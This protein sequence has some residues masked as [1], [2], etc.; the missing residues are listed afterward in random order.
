[1]GAPGRSAAVD[2]PGIPDPSRTDAADVARALD[3]DRG[4]G[5]S[6]AEAARRLFVHYNTMKHRL[7]RIGEL[8]GADLHDPRTRTALALALEA[9]RLVQ[10]P[11]RPPRGGVSGSP[12]PGAGP[13]TGT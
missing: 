11:A 8:L 6:G 5:L 12:R 3:V 2:P 13:T 4:R 7:Q 1:M 9:H 10:P